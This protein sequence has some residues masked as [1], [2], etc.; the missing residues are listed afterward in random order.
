MEEALSSS[1]FLFGVIH[2][3]G[4]YNLI[5]ILS[6]ADVLMLGRKHKKP[7]TT[8]QTPPPKRKNPKHTHGIYV[9]TH[10]DL[11]VVFSV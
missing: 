3:I 1:M 9:Y 6:V 4:F 7:K 5:L 8:N 2:I 10:L 11:W